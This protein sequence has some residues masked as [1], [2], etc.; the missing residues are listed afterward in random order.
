MSGFASWQRKRAPITPGHMQELMA[1][2]SRLTLFDLTGMVT[3]MKE[4]LMLP[5]RNFFQSQSSASS[6]AHQHAIDDRHGRQCKQQRRFASSF[7]C[8]L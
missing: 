5:I 3:D 2:Y 8:K 1:M 4:S 7:D 6:L